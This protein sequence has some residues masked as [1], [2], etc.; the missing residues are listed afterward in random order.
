MVY[1]LYPENILVYTYFFP[2]CSF[3]LV[4][5]WVLQEFLLSLISVAALM[6]LFGNFMH[7]QIEWSVKSGSLRNI[8]SACVSIPSTLKYDD[9]K[10]W[11]VTMY[12]YGISFLL[13]YFIFILG[14]VMGRGSSVFQFSFFRLVISRHVF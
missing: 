9:V 10:T 5:I 12:I 11:C 4:R 6:F 8:D 13:L 2:I 3:Y 14:M 1:L 7:L